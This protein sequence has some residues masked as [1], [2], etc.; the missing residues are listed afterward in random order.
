MKILDSNIDLNSAWEKAREDFFHKTGHHIQ[1]GGI[2]VDQ[3]IATIEKE[4]AGQKKVDAKLDRIGS[5]AVTAMKT[6]ETILAIINSVA[7]SV[8]SS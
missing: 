2:S 8:G 5:L 3:L 1:N 4:R 6:G 7:S